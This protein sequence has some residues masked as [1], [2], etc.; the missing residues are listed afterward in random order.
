MATFH[1]HLWCVRSR[2][3]AWDLPVR[4][5]KRFIDTH[6]AS[7]ER[8]RRMFMPGQLG[9]WRFNPSCGFNISEERT[10]TDD[11]EYL[12]GKALATDSGLSL[13]RL[14]ANPRLH[15]IIRD[16]ERLRLSGVVS[17]AVKDE[18]AVPGREFRLVNREGRDEFQRVAYDRHKIEG[19]NGWSNTWTVSNDFARQPLQARLELL[20][21]AEPYEEPGNL[22][23]LE[24]SGQGVLR[25]RPGPVAEAVMEKE[26]RPPVDMSRHQGLGVW[27]YGDGQGEILNFQLRNAMPVSGVR[28]EHYVLVDFTG[29]RYF[30]LI[31]PEADRFFDYR[32]PYR[33]AEDP[34]LM[35]NLDD[36]DE[37]DAL[38][39]TGQHIYR[40]PYHICNGKLDY[41]RVISLSVWYNNLPAGRTAACRIRSVKAIPIRK[42]RVRNPALTVGGQTV[43]FPVEM[44][45]GQYLEFFSPDECFLY[46]ED[47]KIVSRVD[48]RGAVPVLNS[49][50][51]QLS[52]Q[53]ERLV[54]GSI[55]AHVTV[56]RRGEYL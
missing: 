2:V 14:G 13:I 3:G 8:D 16:Y 38:I 52:F 24:L 39:A 1:H 10:F 25:S 46:G 22:T 15:E 21:S 50:N 35:K 31:E 45:T 17:R 9:W 40:A 18:L 19:T 44:E 55:R 32:W 53:A 20:F 27:I 28:S 42:M 43:V 41:G 29:W 11:I 54:P 30:E 12:C 56:I 36:A 4:G 47:E 7:N 26:F 49:G 37:V 48:P 23:L 34:Y 6:V 5:G 33:L 51:N